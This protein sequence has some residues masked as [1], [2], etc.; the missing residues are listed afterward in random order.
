MLTEG[1]AAISAEPGSR[2]IGLAALG[3]WQFKPCPAL[4]AKGGARSILGVAAKAVHDMSRV[5]ENI[6]GWPLKASRYVMTP[7]GH[8]NVDSDVLSN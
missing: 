4:V 5:D 1:L 8:L 3:T 6:I 2:T 7:E